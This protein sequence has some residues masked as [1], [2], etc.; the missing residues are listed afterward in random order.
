MK[1]FV[2][3][4]L[5]VSL[6]VVGLSFLSPRSIEKDKNA[7]DHFIKKVR[8]E[9][10]RVQYKPRDFI[11]ERRAEELDVLKGHRDDR[12]KAIRSRHDDFIVI[13]NDDRNLYDDFR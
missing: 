9:D 7:S 2:I 6:L 11:R 4:F 12:Q 13:N 3:I 10:Y 1:V 8:H 5:S